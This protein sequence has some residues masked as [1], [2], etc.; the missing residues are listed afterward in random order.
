MLKYRQ[1]NQ[2]LVQPAQA[3]VP[4]RVPSYAKTTTRFQLK[5]HPIYPGLGDP[6]PT[7]EVQDEFAKYISGP[8]TSEKT[9]IFVYWQVSPVTISIRSILSQLINR[10]TNQNSPR[11]S[12]LPWTI[13]RFKRLLYLAN[14]SS[15]QL[16]RLTPRNETESAHP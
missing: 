5:D 3:Q 9:S 14:A 11:S 8:L 13:F 1:E 6:S 10:P 7:G 12:L 16:G 15:R 2:S 4:P